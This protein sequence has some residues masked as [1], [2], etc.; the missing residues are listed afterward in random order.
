MYE[1]GWGKIHE[2]WCKILVLLLD[3]IN[4]KKLNRLTL[5]QCPVSG[6][7]ITKSI[8][9]I[10]QHTQIYLTIAMDS[11]KSMGQAISSWIPLESMN[12]NENHR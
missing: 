12:L 6:D 2:V 10:C 8:K 11:N 1:N 5:L 4:E 7:K 9:L 3:C